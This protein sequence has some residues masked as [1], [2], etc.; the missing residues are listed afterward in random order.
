MGGQSVSVYRHESGLVRPGL[1]SIVKYA[2]QLDVTVE[3]LMHGGPG[4]PELQPPTRVVPRVKA[5]DTEVPMVIAQL[6]ADGRLGRVSPDEIAFLAR[7][8]RVE[9]SLGADDFENM[10]L[11]RRASSSGSVEDRERLNEALRRQAAEHGEH[12]FDLP[13]Q[14][15]P[16]APKPDSVRKSRPNR[17]KR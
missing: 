2:K 11:L 4:G 3:W 14:I 7:Q 8:A 9:P 10:L 13:A 5:S 16:P 12:E 6:L 17:P 15:A 1:D